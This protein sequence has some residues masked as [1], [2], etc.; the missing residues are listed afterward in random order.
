MRWLLIALIFTASAAN[1]KTSL[2]EVSNGSHRLYLGGTIHMLSRTDFPLPSEFDSAYQS[3]DRLVFETDLLQ[4][5]QP[6][7]QQM[8]LKKV[9]LPKPRTLKSVL[10]PETYRKVTA[11]LAQR[12]LTI[13]SFDQMKPSM[14]S[15]SLFR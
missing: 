12:G 13:S 4:L 15:I 6:Q 7:F 2:W 14:V 5:A 9:S 1:A 10:Q 8:L 3:A 11:F